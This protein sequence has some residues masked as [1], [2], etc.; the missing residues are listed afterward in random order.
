MPITRRKTPEVIEQAAADAP[1][2]RRRIR[3]S[4]R[5]SPPVIRRR[6]FRVNRTSRRNRL[7]C[8][9]ERIRLAVN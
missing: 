9:A 1:P 5:P 6:P 4:T 8:P 3:Y 7:E 2:T